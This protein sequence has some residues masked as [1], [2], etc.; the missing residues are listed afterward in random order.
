MSSPLRAVSLLFRRGSNSQIVFPPTPPS[1]PT[2]LHNPI[3][4]C[5]MN[6]ILRYFTE[7]DLKNA[8]A[9]CRG[10]RSLCSSFY[11][12]Q[13]AMNLLKAANIPSEDFKS[14]TLHMFRTP[15]A[16]IDHL[17]HSP[18][19]LPRTLKNGLKFQNETVI[20]NCLEVFHITYPY[21]WGSVEEQSELCRMLFSYLIKNPNHQKVKVILEILCMCPDIHNVYRQGTAIAE[22]ANP[23]EEAIRSLI[24]A[25]EK[26][27]GR[28]FSFYLLSILVTCFS[29]NE[30]LFHTFFQSLITVWNPSHKNYKFAPHPNSS[31][32]GHTLEWIV[33]LKSFLEKETSI[34]DSLFHFAR[35]LEEGCDKPELLPFLLQK[36]PPPKSIDFYSVFFAKE[37]PATVSCKLKARF[38]TYRPLLDI[39]P[40]LRGKEIKANDEKCVKALRDY[41][42]SYPIQTKDWKTVPILKTLYE[43]GHSLHLSMIRDAVI[44]TFSHVAKQ[45]GITTDE[46]QHV[47]SIFELASPK[48]QQ[49]I[50]ECMVAIGIKI[51]QEYGEESD[52]WES[53]KKL[54]EKF[55]TFNRD[56]VS[57]L[58]IHRILKIVSS[59]E[60]H[61]YEKSEN[62]KLS[63]KHDL[64][65]HVLNLLGAPS[66]CDF[67]KCA[68]SDFTKIQGHFVNLRSLQVN[69]CTPYKGIEDFHSLFYLKVVN[70][71]DQLFDVIDKKVLIKLS[72]Y[73]LLKDNELSIK[74]TTKSDWVSCL[75]S[76]SLVNLSNH[77]PDENLNIYKMI[78]NL[79]ELTKF[80]FF[81]HFIS[82]NLFTAL[83]DVK[84]HLTSLILVGSNSY[85]F[86]KDFLTQCPELKELEVGNCSITDER[87]PNFLTGKQLSSFGW[88]VTP[89]SNKKMEL[90]IEKQPNLQKLTLNEPSFE[91]LFLYLLSRLSSLQTLN[92]I[93]PSHQCGKLIRL[94]EE[95]RFQGKLLQVQLIGTPP[96]DWELSLL[97][98][99]FDAKGISLRFV[100]HFFEI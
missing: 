100:P 13:R 94:I 35:H 72:L 57:R 88:H 33:H 56:A 78:S 36:A 52:K 97:I 99:Q 14:G 70:P 24:S 37:I 31:F 91:D 49:T 82:P 43:M 54:I 74:D 23:T 40:V 42:C 19:Y 98:D 60:T 48:E 22:K 63:Q 4:P 92:L 9:V 51:Y 46:Y 16:L 17:Q 59:D 84:P 20:L 53:I 8:A 26:E 58:R 86:P 18:H 90:L 45:N 15:K 79:Q 34:P 66:E 93:I 89:F 27:I 2:K 10:W 67:S 77:S 50:F 5:S 6:L 85:E 73:Q 61:P 25:S 96:S 21:S 81:R 3:A 75:D 38:I 28:R 1:S 29:K 30:N 80:C 11:H 55:R 44:E 95:K 69:G 87:F 12:K 39:I 64:Q 7:D 47:Y 65:I 71:N 68:D 83:N 62:I 41:V 32:H 76:F